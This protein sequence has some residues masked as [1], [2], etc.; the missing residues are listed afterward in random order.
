MSDQASPIDPAAVLKWLYPRA[1]D[2]QIAMEIL[3][4]AIRVAHAQ[5]PTSWAV[6]LKEEFIRINAGKAE[7]LALFADELHFIVDR[8][9]VPAR[10]GVDDQGPGLA[11]I[12]GCAVID[13]SPAEARKEMEAFRD[14]WHAAI[15]AAAMSARTCPYAKHH[16]R[17]LLEYLR[18]HLKPDLAIPSPEVPSKLI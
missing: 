1:K 16:S 17:E 18:H 11:S 6:S 5:R 2:R 4:E 10:F 13:L 9:R 14:G 12:P 8:T 3:V 7:V 15:R